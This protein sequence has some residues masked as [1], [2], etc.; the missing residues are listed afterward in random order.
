MRICVDPDR[1][2]G[3][4]QCNFTAPQLLRLRDEDGHAEAILDEVPPELQELAR[5]AADSC[6]EQAILLSEDAGDRDGV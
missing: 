5:A 1:C 6:P 2:Q 4:T 3:H